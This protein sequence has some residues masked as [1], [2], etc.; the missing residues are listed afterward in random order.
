MHL[1]KVAAYAAIVAN[2]FAACPGDVNGDC[3]PRLQKCSDV[4][5]DKRQLT[6]G[7]SEAVK[8]IPPGQIV[9]GAKSRV[10]QADG[11][12]A[13]PMTDKQEQ[14]QTT[15]ITVTGSR[16]LFLRCLRVLTHAL[17]ATTPATRPLLLHYRHL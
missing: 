6:P 7:R 15:L 4:E 8:E 17:E 16:Y 3:P 10:Q 12:I 14:E 1:I 11:Q 9:A 5:L 2:A 13:A